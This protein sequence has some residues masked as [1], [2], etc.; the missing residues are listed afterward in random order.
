MF[1]KANYLNSELF[2]EKADYS[3]K[4]SYLSIYENVRVNGDNGNLVADRL[5]FD[6]KYKKLDLKKEYF[7]IERNE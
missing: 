6:V 5:L 7:Q 1:L 3:N 2:A 4:E